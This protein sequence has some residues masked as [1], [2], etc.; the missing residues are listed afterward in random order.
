MHSFHPACVGEESKHGVSDI[1]MQ[2]LTRDAAR[3]ARKRE[4]KY[5][6]ALHFRMHQSLHQSAHASTVDGD[7]GICRLAAVRYLC[8]TGAELCYE[9]NI[10]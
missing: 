10:K 5:T 1:Y 8:S 6:G 4:L 2:M 7:D 9:L 3:I